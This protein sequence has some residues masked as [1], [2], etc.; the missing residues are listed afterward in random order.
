MPALA[1]WSGGGSARWL[2][3]RLTLVAADRDRPAKRSLVRWWEAASFPDYG[4][5]SDEPSSVL[6]RC[7]Q[8][9]SASHSR[10]AYPRIAAMMTA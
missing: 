3:P 5:E 6:I 10:T 7:R 1:R 2:W 4:V 8:A 9:L